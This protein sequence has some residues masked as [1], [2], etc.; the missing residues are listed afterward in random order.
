MPVGTFLLENNRQAYHGQEDYTKSVLGFAVDAGEELGV[1]AQ[2]AGA[3]HDY[4]WWAAAGWENG[5]D[6]C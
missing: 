3:Y 1:C 2:G 5:G 6:F 4:V